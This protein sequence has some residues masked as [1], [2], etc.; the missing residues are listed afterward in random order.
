MTFDSK[1]TRAHRLTFEN[2]CQAF[3]REL[4]RVTEQKDK[5]KA[6]LLQKVLKR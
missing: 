2:F 4:Y 1:Y 5:L 6:H 3:K